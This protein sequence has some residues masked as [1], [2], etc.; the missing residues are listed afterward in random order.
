MKPLSFICNITF[1][2][3]LSILFFP[4]SS[5]A[6]AKDSTLI[7][8]NKEIYISA[9]YGALTFA[10]LSEASFVIPQQG[11]PKEIGPFYLKFEKR[12]GNFGIGLNLAYLRDKWIYHLQGD[13]FIVNTKKIPVNAIETDERS[14]YSI[15]LRIN[16]YFISTKKFEAY[17]GFGVGGR[18]GPINQSSNFPGLYRDPTGKGNDDFPIGFEIS[19]GFR[20]SLC[21][22]ISLYAEAGLCKSILQAGLTY[23]IPSK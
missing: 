2:S 15:L 10:F 8:S 21:K 7:L 20:Y 6:Q 23:R 5:I 14:T 11:Y 3:A 19:C 13:S 22:K 12:K 18:L 16:H 4:N 1:F 9:G 17:Y